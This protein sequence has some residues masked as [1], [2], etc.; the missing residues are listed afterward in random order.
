[1][2]TQPG[3]MADTKRR[4]TRFLDGHVDLYQ[5]M[6]SLPMQDE[7]VRLVLLKRKVEVRESRRH[8]CRL[9]PGMPPSAVGASTP[10]RGWAGP[11]TTTLLLY[12]W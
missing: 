10:L 6:L 11:A 1:M 12:S 9:P 2:I 5:D 8:L 4:A 7:F 3:S